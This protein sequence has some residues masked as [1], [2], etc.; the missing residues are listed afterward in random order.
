MNQQ[1]MEALTFKK[2]NINNKKINFVKL[3]LFV[4]LFVALM[5]IIASYPLTDSRAETHKISTP[6]LVQK[7]SP[8]VVNI[9]TKQIIKQAHPNIRFHGF[10]NGRQGNPFE[11]FDNLFNQFLQPHM[12][13]REATSLG[14]GFIIDEDGYIVTNSHVVAKAKEIM[15]S[16][17]ADEQFEAEL[18]GIDKETDLALLKI[19]AGKPLPYVEFGDSDDARIGEDVL[20]IGNP[21]G[22][23]GTVTRGIIS[24][25]SRDINAGKFDDFIQT[26]AAINK[27]NSGG[28]MFNMTGEVIGISTAIFSPDGR[29]G[30]VGIGFAIPSTQAKPIIEQIRANGFVERGWL[31]VRIQHVTEEIAQSLGLKKPSG[32]LVSEVIKASPA[33]KY[34]LKLGDLIVAF[35]GKNIEQMKDLPRIVAETDVSK[36]VDVEILRQGKKKKIK[37]VIGKL[38]AEE[39]EQKSKAGKAKKSVGAET[40]VMGLKLI[41]IDD[42]NIK[43]RF[44]IDS[45]ATGVMVVDIKRDTVAFN[46]GVRKGD[47]IEQVNSVKISNPE[48]FQ[49]QLELLKNSGKKSVLLFINR[50]GNRLFIGFTLNKAGDKPSDK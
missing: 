24:A 22:L 9:S 42:V 29:A 32:A 45:S 33:E 2:V 44:K 31:G 10:G 34:G 13:E 11:D 20:V 50:S 14:S 27:G 36:K 19:D 47:I 49:E 7:L 35:D 18:I 6:D 12:E 48:E 26:D 41:A 37:I 3:L 1:S 46:S 17:V 39:S 25:R 30:N 43:R 15:V 8:A 4:T 23:G 16:L 28:P 5:L 38:D 40:F 21:F